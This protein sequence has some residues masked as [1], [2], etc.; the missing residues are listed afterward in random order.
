VKSELTCA[1]GLAVIEIPV[2]LCRL[3][4]RGRGRPQFHELI[5]CIDNISFHCN[6]L[7]RS[8]NPPTW[9]LRSG[10]TGWAFVSQPSWRGVKK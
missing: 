1:F 5:I 8:R 10:S 4:W 9:F 7:A 6:L 3:R 2:A